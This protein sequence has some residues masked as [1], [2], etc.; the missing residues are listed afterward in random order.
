MAAP[1]FDY[2]AAGDLGEALDVLAAHGEDAKVLA[3][4]QSLVP[5]MHLRLAR[6]GVVL[7]INRLPGLDRAAVVDGELR[8][9]ALVRHRRLERPPV[10][11]PLGALLAAAAGHVGHLPIRVRGTFAGSLAH[12]DPAAEWCLIAVAV[13]ARLVLASASGERVV[14]AGDFFDDPFVTALRPDELITEVR[15]PLLGPAA[16]VAFRERAS[17][18]GAFA[19]AAACAAVEVEGG[20]VSAARLAVGGVAG[21]PLALPAAAATVV[22]SDPADVAAR[23][24]E[25]RQ[26]VVAAVD[27]RD[28]PLVPADYRRALA[29]E[30]AADAV[31]AAVGDAVKR[32]AARR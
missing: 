14:P 10:A 17:T 7:D 4:G 1:A 26:E 5:M 32:E 20:R 24:G 21:R 3:G 27:P 22:G 2:R 28:D 25:L 15:L 8:L 12:A 18:A 30:L 29:A 16:G 23:L 9:G 19:Q 31:A 11:D 6:P 13:G